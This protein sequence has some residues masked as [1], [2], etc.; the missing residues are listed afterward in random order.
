MYDVTNE[1]YRKVLCSAV[2]VG[3]TGKARAMRPT[4]VVLSHDTVMQVRREHAYNCPFQHGGDKTQ[5]DR[6]FGI[7]VAYDD[8][9]RLGEV[10]LAEDTAN[11]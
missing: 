2:Q 8:S 3:M 6:L 1:L 4:L 11:L 10:I 9:L 7:R 5:P